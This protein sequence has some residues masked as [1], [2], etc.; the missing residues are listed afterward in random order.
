MR[1]QKLTK[2]GTSLALV[3]ALGAPMV[4][5]GPSPA[6]NVATVESSVNWYAPGR[7]STLLQNLQDINAK[8][9]THGQ[10]LDT[11]SRAPRHSWQSHAHYLSQVRDQVNEAGKIISE[12]Q[13][14]QHGA[15]PWQQQAIARIH[16]VALDLAKHTSEAIAYLAG[17]QN[18]LFAPEYRDHL[19]A[20][21]DRATEMRT[22]VN[23]FVDYGAAQQQMQ[24][25]GQKLEIAG[26]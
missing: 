26:S 10:T 3:L 20:I 16:P 9:D 23:S 6:A 17:N 5:A 15:L 7:V 4:V 2:I 12:L 18:W 24:T 13:S 22:T 21:S 8:L 19:A 1:F 14:I 25:L 11:L